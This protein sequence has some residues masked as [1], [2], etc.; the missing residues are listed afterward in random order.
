M[1]LSDFNKAA[2]AAY[3]QLFED[4]DVSANDPTAREDVM[5]PIREEL[6]EFTRENRDPDIE[7]KSAHGRVKHAVD[8]FTRLVR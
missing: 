5:K 1:S 2:T 7:E 4:A 8:T 6:A 3:R